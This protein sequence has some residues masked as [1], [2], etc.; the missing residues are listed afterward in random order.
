MPP[1]RHRAT[2]T[3]MAA[4]LRDELEVGKARLTLQRQRE[5][6]EY[7][8]YL[9]EN[10]LTRYRA[11]IERRMG[12]A[13]TEEPSNAGILDVFKS[14]AG[15]PAILQGIL[16]MM[17][18]TGLPGAVQ[19]TQPPA[20]TTASAPPTPAAPPQPAAAPVPLTPQPAPAMHPDSEML[21]GMVKGKTAGELAAWLIGVPLP[22]ARQI[23][24]ALG[25][26]TDAQLPLLWQQVEGQS[27]SLTGFVRWFQAQDIYMATVSAVR[28]Q[29][30]AQ[31]AIKATES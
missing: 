24:Q 22:I 23:V 5:E 7:L 11:M 14:L 26:A 1:K 6:R 27:P 3:E 19:Q 28:T 16:G 31:A 2:K 12:L 17:G 13:A 25:T 9:R 4:R 10:D 18:L 30:A 20:L 29:L 15:N 8:D 21:I